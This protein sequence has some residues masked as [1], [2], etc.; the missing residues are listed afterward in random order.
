MDGAPP[1]LL[2]PDPPSS[3]LPFDDAT[4]VDRDVMGVAVGDRRASGV[5]IIIPDDGLL[6]EDN[7]PND[8]PNDNPQLLLSTEEEEVD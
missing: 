3:T 8:P 2:Y 5:I 1:I 7:P 6:E 4:A